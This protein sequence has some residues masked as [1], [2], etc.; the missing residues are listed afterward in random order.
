VTVAPR[1]SRSRLLDGNALDLAPSFVARALDDAHEIVREDANGSRVGARIGAYELLEEIGRGGMGAVYL[2]RRA[3][4]VFERNVAI[5]LLCR[6]DAHVLE[7][8]RQERQVLASLNHPNIARLYDGGVSDGSQ[9]YIVME[10]VDGVP[11]LEYCAQHAVGIEARLEMVRQIA[12]ALQYAHQSLVIHRDIKSSNVL[13]TREGRVKVLDFGIAKLL[14]ASRGMELTRTGER[15]LTPANAAPEQITSSPTTAATDVYQ[16]GLLAYELLTGQRALAKP[17]SLYE[18]ARIVCT[19]EPVKP[20]TAAA[21]ARTAARPE[22]ALGLGRRANGTLLRGDLDAILLKAL[23]KNPRDRYASMAALS[24][25][26]RAHQEARPVSARRQSLSYQA[27]RF[28]VRH[29]RSLAAAAAL[30]ATS[31]VYGVTSLVQAGKVREALTVAETENAKA[32]QVTEFLIDLFESSDPNVPREQ[33]LTARELLERGRERLEHGLADAPEVR[34]QAS[35]VLGRIYYNLGAYGESAA[36]LE[37]ALEVAR[38]TG[39]GNDPETADLLVSLGVTYGALDQWEA[40]QTAFEE[41]LRALGAA[42]QH[43]ARRAETLNASGLLLRRAGRYEEAR[44]RFER[45][46]RLLG[47]PG[48]A[49]SE[50]LPVALNNLATLNADLGELDDAERNLRAAVRLQGEMLGTEHVHYSITLNNLGAIL[51]RLERFAESEP[52]HRRA[53][54][55]QEASL[56]DDHPYVAQTLWSLGGLMQRSGD[57]HAAEVHLRRA[58]SITESAY[59][60]SSAPMASA[61]SR[62]GDVLM[63]QRRYA[64]ADRALR[65]AL[66]IDAAVLDPGHPKLARD[67]GRLAELAHAT[68]DRALARTRFVAA[69]GYLPST[70][71][72]ASRT[73]IAYAR[74]LADLDRPREAL[75]FA[76]RAAELRRATLPAGHSSVA[77]AQSTVDAIAALAG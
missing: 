32:E 75:T 45:A 4:G 11:L 14:D 34:A 77:E 29:R 42:P 48:T 70:G 8:F 68:G 60:R 49:P 36:L 73:W 74:L 72:E 71:P 65:E 40:A 16:L 20:S 37:A 35:F 67:Y 28:V 27:A 10:H 57:L 76:R 43:A 23:R 41:G 64:S 53:L 2:A 31:V 46:I 12:D 59:G 7:R 44:G 54:E 3:D 1:P 52:L 17:D 18:M 66:R 58:L 51:T 5:K 39:R 24:A 50:E 13:V 19:V 62:L 56:G 6:R 9:P 22:R 15:A 21:A 38:Q 63:Q 69:L 33:P 30:L 55:L 61:L 26:L 47:A 25:D